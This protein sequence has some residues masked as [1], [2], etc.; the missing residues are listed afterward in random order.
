M[1]INYKG[2]RYVYTYTDTYH[3][4]FK[5]KRFLKMHTKKTISHRT[6]ISKN[7]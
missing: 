4:V 1:S 5:D 6:P 7:Q 2:H 3:D